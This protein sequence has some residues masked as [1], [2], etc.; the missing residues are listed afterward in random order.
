VENTVAAGS[1]AGD[2]V[3]SYVNGQ[4]ASRIAVVRTFS[5]VLRP[6]ERVVDSAF[7]RRA[8][9]ASNA[10]VSGPG[11]RVSVAP[12]A[13]SVSVDHTAYSS[14]SDASLRRV[15]FTFHSAGEIRI[16]TCAEQ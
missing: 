7:V 6:G 12:A 16:T 4:D 3:S 15:R 5:F 8:E 1:M 14:G 2:K 9:Q 10:G 11:E 13:A